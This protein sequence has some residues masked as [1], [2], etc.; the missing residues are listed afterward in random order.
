MNSLSLTSRLLLLSLLFVLIPLISWLL[1]AKFEKDIER[2]ALDQSKEQAQILG[3]FV[4][5][6]LQTDRTLK[7]QFLNTTQQKQFPIALKETALLI[8]GFSDEWYPYQSATTR[9]RNFGQDAKLTVIEDKDFVYGLFEVEDNSIVYRKRL[10][11]TD[12]SDKITLVLGSYQMQFMPMAPGKVPALRQTA[13]GYREVTPIYAVWQ[14][15]TEGY[16]LEFR[17]PQSLVGKTISAEITDID[18]AQSGVALQGIYSFTDFESLSLHSRLQSGVLSLLE[19][20]LYRLTLTNNQGEV[21]YQFGQLH[22]NIRANWRNRIWSSAI[23]EGTS[24]SLLGKK[25]ISSINLDLALTG[26]TQSELVNEPQLSAFSRVYKPLYSN[27]QVVGAMILESSPVNE[28]LLLRDFWLRFL[29]LLGLIWGIFIWW[30]VKQSRRY[31]QRIMELRDLTEGSISEEGQIRYVID[32][33]EEYDDEVSDLTNSFSLLTNR[34]KQ[35][36]DYQ[37]KLASRLNHELRTPIAII[38]SSLDNINRESLSADELQLID[39][40]QSGAVRMSQTI[41]RLSEANRL[42]Q[43]IRSA[44]KEPFDMIPVLQDLI[45]AY[46]TNWADH[47]FELILGVEEARVLGSKD[48]FVQM[49]DKLISNAVD[50]DDKSKPIKISLRR[51]DRQLVLSVSNA[52]P[53]IAKKNLHDVFS[54]MHSSRKHSNQHLGLGL[55]VARLIASFHGAKVNA[56]NEVEVSGVSIN[57]VWRNKHF[58]A[59]P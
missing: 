40:A 54:L 34:L 26:R 14:E 28:K 3:G 50:F 49:L 15:R 35:Y 4:N 47:A 43:A 46:R 6:L 48:L 58:T 17:V 32:M 37:E 33:D 52:G 24:D 2:N 23:E 30:V 13:D 8:D 7:Q 36:H 57:I 44:D 20:E 27:Q 19:P 38:R 18:R 12:L 53:N 31:S 29:L 51:K 9:I 21:L 25:S 56:E 41:S 5:Q 22:T 45:V 42:E 55:Y 11:L 16:Q 10:D 1:L 59:S 39:N